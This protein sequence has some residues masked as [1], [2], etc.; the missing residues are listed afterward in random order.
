MIEPFQLSKVAEKNQKDI[1]Q[2]PE[3]Y[4]CLSGEIEGS[5]QAVTIKT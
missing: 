4:I 3:F 2:S 1:I 5:E